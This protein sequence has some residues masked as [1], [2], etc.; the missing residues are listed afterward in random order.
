MTNLLVYIYENNNNGNDKKP[1]EIWWYKYGRKKYKT[2]YLHL[3]SFHGTQSDQ[4]SKNERST[5]IP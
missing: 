4:A 3:K 5:C 1:I 2:M